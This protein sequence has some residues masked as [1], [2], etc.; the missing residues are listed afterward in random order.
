MT[1]T[2]FQCKVALAAYTSKKARSR[3]AMGALSVAHARTT[4]PNAKRGT[5]QTWRAMQYAKR[6]WL[7]FRKSAVT[8]R[9][10]RCEK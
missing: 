4:A 7:A 9:R 8:K 10:I 3:S 6:I 2:Y 5:L 1:W